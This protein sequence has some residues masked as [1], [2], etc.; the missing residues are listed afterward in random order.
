MLNKVSFILLV[1]IFTAQCAS[2][3]KGTS[4]KVDF[5]SKPQGAQVY[6]NG[7]YM[8]DTPIRLKL[9]SKDNYAIEFV[10]EGYKSKIFN[11]TN[12]VNAGWIVLDVICGIIPVIVDAST[13]AWY[14]LD[15]KNVNA[16]LIKQQNY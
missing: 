14:E 16:V 1:C 3:I 15:Q 2:I 10:L 7:N 11:I 5:N 4:N 8:G 6:V 12:H 9:V 13:G